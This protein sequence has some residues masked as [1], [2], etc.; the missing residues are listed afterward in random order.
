MSATGS[1]TSPETRG[2]LLSLPVKA[3]RW[4]F[5]L[6]LN[7]FREIVSNSDGEQFFRLKREREREKIT[8]TTF[9]PFTQM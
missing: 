6:T 4:P 9:P 1:E 3:R 8:S 7:F 5:L 2:L